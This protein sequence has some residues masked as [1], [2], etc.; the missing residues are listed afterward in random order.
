MDNVDYDKVSEKA[1]KKRLN[2]LTNNLAKYDKIFN[3]VKQVYN[4]AYYRRKD[5]NTPRYLFKSRQTGNLLKRQ[6]YYTNATKLQ[7]S[8]RSERYEISKSLSRKRAHSVKD[9]VIA[10]IVMDK[11]SNPSIY[12]EW[13]SFDI[14][15]VTTS[16]SILIKP[17]VD[18]TKILK[19][20]GKTM[21]I[22]KIINR[23][24]KF[25]SRYFQRQSSL[26]FTNPNFIGLDNY[27]KN[28]FRKEIKE[29]VSKELDPNGCVHSIIFRQPK[30]TG[31]RYHNTL[32]QIV[33][34]FKSID[35]M[36]WEERR[37][38]SC[39]SFS[40]YEFNS[41]FKRLLN[42]YGWVESDNYSSIYQKD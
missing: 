8:D 30:G 13:L 32:I 27:I 38:S 3:K 21:L 31:Y 29:R 42:E 23:I 10:F 40:E 17:T 5:N 39:K 41:S 6:E 34:R 1:L 37:N 26:D 35:N 28:V 19:D 16:G 24:E 15:E 2:T 36:D 9:F 22:S 18:L 7:T 25:W 4:S 11:K 33:P 14:G 20:K 12:P